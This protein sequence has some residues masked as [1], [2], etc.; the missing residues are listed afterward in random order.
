M[1]VDSWIINMF[2]KCGQCWIDFCYVFCDIGM[3]GGIVDDYVF[4]VL[5]YVYYF[6][7]IIEVD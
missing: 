1:I 6:G 5:G 4:V 3:G 7:Y 2:G